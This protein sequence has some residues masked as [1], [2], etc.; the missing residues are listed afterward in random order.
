MKEINMEQY[1]TSYKHL[2]G[3][4]YLCNGMIGFVEDSD[5]GYYWI[6]NPPNLKSENVKFYLDDG[7][8]VNDS[9]TLGTYREYMQLHYP[10]Y[11]NIWSQ[12]L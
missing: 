5:V 8:H 12:Q 9:P 10:E 4:E 6:D 1:I 3:C 2:I 11:E 7:T